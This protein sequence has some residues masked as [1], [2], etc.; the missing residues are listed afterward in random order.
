MGWESIAGAVGGSLLS[1]DIQYQNA[2]GLM[3]KQQSWQEYMSGTAYQRAMRD[4]GAAGL[5]PILAYSQGG[6]STPSG[7]GPSASGPDLVGALS[8]AKQLELADKQ[9]EKMDAEIA[10]AKEQQGV[11]RTEGAKNL[12]TADS[13][14]QG[15]A[16]SRA[17]TLKLGA[18]LPKVDEERAK[19]RAETRSSSAKA[20]QDEADAARRELIGP[21]SFVTDYAETA[22]RVMARVYGGWKSWLGLSGDTPKEAAQKESNRKGRSHGTTGSW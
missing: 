7:G 19:L 15:T 2:R 22:A 3:S 14:S 8:T 1:S 6:A 4:M 13:I 12:A 16:E 18:E 17:R 10:V 9:K 11:L 20:F 5:N 21:K